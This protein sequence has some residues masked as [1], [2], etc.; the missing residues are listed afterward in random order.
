MFRRR[1][2]QALPIASEALEQLRSEWRGHVLTLVGIVWGTS[3]VLL[4]LGLGTGFTEFLDLGVS[5]TGDRW[6]RVRGGYTT[7]EGSGRAAGRRIEFH[8]EDVARLLSGAPSASAISAVNTY[9]MS[10]E[11]PSRTR[12]TVVSAGS[13][14]LQRIQNH[15]VARGRYIDA[16][17]M[18]NQLQVTV[19]G[20]DLAEIL[21]AQSDPI[22]ERVHFNGV[23]FD[24]IGV[25]AKKGFQ[26]MT[27]SDLHDRM[28]FIPLNAGRRVE[29]DGDVVHQINLNPWRMDEVHDLEAEV[30]S[31]LWPRHH[32]IDGDD[33]AIMMTNVPDVM[34]SFRNIFVAFRIVLGAIG[35]VT[36]AMAG[37]GVANLMLAVVNE[38]RR[39]FAMRR[40]C[41]ARRSDI[42][43]Q[44]LGET[45]AIVVAGG[46]LGVVLG[47]GLI[48]LIAMAPL[49]PAVPTPTPS[50]SVL[51]TTFCVLVGTGL[52]AGIAPARI[53]SRVDPAA[54]LRVT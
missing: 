11:S 1:I 28:A 32:L 43:F 41:G 53:A 35:T 12:A 48:G 19:L 31:I 7:R 25:L 37:V 20:A 3:T 8:D 13:P 6:L 9:F 46:L 2:S 5:R 54:A 50:M 34:R 33:E 47:L 15:I 52:G 24:V 17:D 23:P 29:D 27:D 44:L 22:G 39:E 36:L 51:I 18:S 40:A 14:D 30:R 45:T 4:L 10:V 38:R 21:F 49:P 26:M 16:G 42:V